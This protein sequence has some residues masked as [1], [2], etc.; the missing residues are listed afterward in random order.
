MT[1][2]PVL[3][4]SNLAKSYGQHQVL[5][6]ISFEVERGEVVAVIGPSGCGKSTLLRCLTWLE[7]P[8]EGE[9]RVGGEPFGACMVDGRRKIQSRRALDRMRPRIGMV[10]QQFHLWPHL[11]SLENIIRPQT[12]VL[13]RTYE[14]ARACAVRLLTA[15]GL[16]DQA[17]KLPSTLSG[18]QRQRVAI[19][20]AMAMDPELLLFDEPT[21]ALDPELVGDVL[22]LLRDLAAQG[23]TM[24]VVT[25]DIGFARRVADRAIFLDQGR[26]VGNGLVDEIFG[27]EANPRIATFVEG[28]ARP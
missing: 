2:S 3:A 4:V 9:I 18:G 21:A 25:H 8:E 14:D 23:T 5:K 28:S 7:Q 1:D 26:V 24:V 13:K 15:L 11:S 27:G 20:R 19:A 6:D 22:K 10:F 12:V 16:A 17:D